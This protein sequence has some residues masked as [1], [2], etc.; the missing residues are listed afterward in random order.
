MS[1]KCGFHLTLTQANLLLVLTLGC[2]L[3]GNAI[4]GSICR[5]GEREREKER[6]KAKER[7]EKRMKSKCFNINRFWVITAIVIKT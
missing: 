3:L 6:R 7:K 4:L 2:A 5:N 1:S